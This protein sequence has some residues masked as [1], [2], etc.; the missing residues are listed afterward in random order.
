MNELVIDTDVVSY[1][2]KN[3][4]RAVPY[5]SLLTGNTLVVSFMTVA[6]LHRWA[7]ERQ[8]SVA[9]QRAL[10]RYIRHFTIHPHTYELCRTWAEVTVESRRNGRPIGVADAWHAAVAVLHN[11]PLVTNNATDYAGISG[12]KVVTV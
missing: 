3:D 12:L 2:F 10:D 8:W 9:R 6:E 7:L 1:I 4:T 11:L 5:L